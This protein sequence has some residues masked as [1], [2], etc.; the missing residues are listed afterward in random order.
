MDIYIFNE[1]ST[2][3]ASIYQAKSDLAIFVHTCSKARSLGLQ[4]LHLHADIGKNLYELPIAPNYTVSQWLQESE[5]DLKNQFRRI[6]TDSPLL[7]DNY[8][9][10]KE[11]NELSEFTIMLD[12]KAKSA[13]GL[14]AAHLLDTLCV[15]FLSKNIW[16]V[17]EIK[18]LNHWYLRTDGSEV[19]TIITVKH[20]SRPEHLDEHKTWI[21]QHKQ[22]RKDRLAK[23][24]DLWK[25][26]QDFFPHLILCGEVEKQF[27]KLGKSKNF[28]QIIEI[29]KRLDKY[30]EDWQDGSYSDQAVRQYGLDASGETEFTLRKYGNQRKFRLP[31][32]TKVLFEKHVKTGDLRFHFYPDNNTKKVYVGYI[33]KH[34]STISDP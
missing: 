25:Q 22:N 27:K 7:S 17:D 29:L 21:E 28:E 24:K 30:A 26:R 12:G 15:S 11:K 18:N 9:E 10:A 8:S 19:N 14:G 32:R 34:L 6:M 20:A 5:E 13:V 1:L 2:P 33:G 31:D 23:T 3:F 16:D 4:N